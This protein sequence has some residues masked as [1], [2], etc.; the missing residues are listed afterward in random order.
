MKSKRTRVY[1]FGQLLLT[2]SVVMV[3][4]LLLLGSLLFAIVFSQLSAVQE[5]TSRYANVMQLASHI[6]NQR[7]AFNRYLFQATNES[8]RIQAL[9]DMKG[10]EAQAKLQLQRLQTTYESNAEQ[11]FLL[12]GIRNGL[13]FIAQQQEQ[14][15]ERLPLDVSG[16]TRYYVIE[17]TYSYLDNYVYS[18]FLS[19]AVTQ[20][21]QA[22]E[23]MQSTIANIRL[24][25]LLLVIFFAF[26]Y[27]LAIILIVRSLAHPIHSMV[28]TARQITKGNLETP[29]LP[30]VGPSE[31]RF[32]EQSLNSMKASLKDRIATLDENAQLEK[33]I[34]QQELQQVKVKR[35]LDRARLLTLQAQINPHFLFNA[36]NTISRTALFE[37]A[38]RTAELVTDLAGIFR[39]M[40]D[41]RTTVRM[42]EELE[43]IRKYLK[44]QK[45]RFGERLEY[46]ILSNEEVHSILIPPLII[47]PLVEN[48]IIHGLEPLEDGG[49]VKV[50]LE[51][52]KRK[53]FITVQDSGV[54]ITESDKSQVLQEN[55]AVDNSHIGMT[56]VLERI[57]LYYGTRAKMEIEQAEPKGTVIRLTLPIRRQDRLGG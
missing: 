54:G 2:Y 48:A 21:A 43:F 55:Q 27:T 5:Q 50:V 31:I 36:M 57:K 52:I 12:R 18:R 42:E 13:D 46:E 22:V 9:S 39:Y 4:S 15:M 17:T 33:R 8:Q 14:L 29:D 51:S 41:Q 24:L 10:A 16:F 6:T 25:S 1:S 32:L 40:L 34:H 11:Y 44:I 37:D 19:S 3:L 47:Q 30:A 26:L 53:L 45:I 28:E 56:N 49:F 35:E 23:K 7:E 20:D 38:D